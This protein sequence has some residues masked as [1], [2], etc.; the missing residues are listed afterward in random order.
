MEDSWL[1]Q[2][3]DDAKDWELI[4]EPKEVQLEVVDT[5]V[6][7]AEKVAEGKMWIRVTFRLIGEDGFFRQIFH[8]LN[9]PN[10][11]DDSD[12]INAKKLRVNEFYDAVGIEPEQRMPRMHEAWRNRMCRAIVTLRKDPEY[13]DSN[14]IQ[15]FVL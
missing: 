9:F 15:Q 6:A 11:T 4:K 2:R 1:D 7:S 13:G 10:S 5:K 14:V 12:V 3:T 8:Y